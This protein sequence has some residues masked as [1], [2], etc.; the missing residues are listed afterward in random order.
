VWTR[1][2][3]GRNCRR[4]RCES[5]AVD[6]FIT[7]VMTGHGEFYAGI[8]FIIFILYVPI[9]MLGTVR[10]KLGEKTIAKAISAEVRR[11]FG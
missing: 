10:A 1:A 2:A 3:A 11:R 8:I 4:P 5:R 9:G 7:A 6:G